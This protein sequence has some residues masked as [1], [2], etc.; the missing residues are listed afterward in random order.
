MNPEPR[1]RLPD[2]LGGAPL[3]PVILSGGSGTRLWPASRRRR[4]K[5]LLALVDER[6]MLRATVDRTRA[7]P[8]ARSPIVV[9]NRSHRLAVHRE[10]LAAGVDDA[11]V[12]LEPVARNTAPAVA[13]A[14]YLVEGD[15]LLLVLPAD[16]VI[17][18][19][20]GFATAVGAG[21]E[22]ALQGYLVT[23]GIEPTHPA[24][25]YGYI[26]LGEPVG[27]GRR[28]AE[29]KEKP[30][31]ETAERYLATGRY[32][33]NSGMFLFRASRYLEELRRFEPDIDGAVR[34]A[35]SAVRADGPFRELDPEE[36]A[37]SPSSSIDYAVA[38]RTDRAAVVPMS[39]GWDD[40]GSWDALWEI[41]DHDPRGNVVIGDVEAVDTSGCLLRSSGRLVAAVGVED[42]IV[43]ETP[44]AVLVAGR[45]RSQEVKALVERLQEEQRQ[46]VETDGCEDRP[47]GRFVTLE[48]GPG[49][50]VLRLWLEPGG[51]MSLQTHEH[52]SEYFIVV[53]GVARVQV[54]QTTRLV[55]ARESVFVP[56]G[57]VHRLENPDDTERLEMIE[58]DVGT[59]VGE[60]DIRRY[61]DV[62]GRAE[63][64]G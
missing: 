50:R 3:V 49:F 44:D 11:A 31:R 63:R 28:V 35:T 41:G 36:F 23:F 32:L 53:R 16:H 58:V 7:L 12:V 39:A 34:R 33:W 17:R 14:A 54:G 24:T 37:A 27:P 59:Y 40:V 2:G 45:G 29:F 52:R 51:K 26:R 22:L 60:D 48:Q 25:G 56:A 47:W 18:N 19:E 5:Q 10:L 38:E 6:T 64:Q 43:V 9:C 42:T 20:D 1:V 4:P 21:I 30:D 8:D 15:P 55:P 57:E 46:E 13:A 61:M 62:Y